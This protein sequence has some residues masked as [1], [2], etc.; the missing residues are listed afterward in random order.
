[1]PNSA[2]STLDPLETPRLLLRRFLPS[3][4]ESL[5]PIYADPEVMRFIGKG[6]RTRAETEAALAR[7]IGHWERHG[8]GMWAV[9]DRAQ[10]ILLGRCGLQHLDHTPEVELGYTLARACWGR[11]IATEAARA[12]LKYGF[13]TVGLERIV[14]VTRHQ[15][16]ASRRVLEKVG[17]RFEKEA[18]FYQADCL[19]FAIARDAWYQRTPRYG[20]DE[21]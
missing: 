14:G 17:L 9:V 13:E 7:M 6:V 3:D 19:Y 11:G 15:N 1:M 20:A 4:L 18:H 2:R 12:S 8:F 5:L 21:R 10:G 16:L